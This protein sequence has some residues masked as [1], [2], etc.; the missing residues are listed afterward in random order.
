LSIHQNRSIQIFTVTSH[1]EDF[2]QKVL[3]KIEENID[4]SEFTIEELSQEFT[5]SRSVFFKKVK[6]ITGCPPGEFLRDIRMKRAAQILESGEFMVKE[7]SYMVGISDTKYFT[8]CFETKFGISPLE[9]KNRS[10]KN[11]D[12]SHEK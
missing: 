11:K 4:N 10:A 6:S 3:N 1:D 5:L 9:Y 7:V 8:K 12:T 2:I